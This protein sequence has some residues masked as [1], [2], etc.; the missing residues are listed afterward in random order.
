ML[1]AYNIC[2]EVRGKIDIL[3][4][5]PSLVPSKHQYVEWFI[6]YSNTLQR[7]ALRAWLDPDGKQVAAY[8]SNDAIAKTT[9]YY[10]DIDGI[11]PISIIAID[12][13]IVKSIDEPSR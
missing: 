6:P 10:I 2:T 8:D 13:N 12:I 9:T 5:A 11:W 7:M 4:K 1:K 3:R